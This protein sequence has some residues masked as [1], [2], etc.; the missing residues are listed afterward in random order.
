MAANDLLVV[1]DEPVLRTLISEGLV[2]AGYRVR[3]AAGGSEALEMVARQRPELILL[4]LMMPEMDGWE[5]LRRL[6]EDPAT[7]A[8]PVMAVTADM[9][10]T[11]E[12]IRT[13]GF[14]CHLP[15]P[16]RMREL[17]GAVESCLAAAV[18]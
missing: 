8:I 14:T 9:R 18:G 3:V 7:Q 1:D 13:A 11:P 10:A 16:F 4:D 15:K 12:R 6:R 17:V 5:T 2:R